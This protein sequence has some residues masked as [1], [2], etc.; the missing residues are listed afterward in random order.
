MKLQICDTPLMDEM[1]DAKLQEAAKCRNLSVLNVKRLL[2]EVL[3]DPDVVT[4]FRQ[5]LIGDGEDS[6]NIKYEPKMTR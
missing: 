4:L 1:I 2:K 6:R 3:T 5:Y